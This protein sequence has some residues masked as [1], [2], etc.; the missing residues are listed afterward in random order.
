[1]PIIIIIII[2]FLCKYQNTVVNRNYNSINIDLYYFP[3]FL[4]F[5]LTTRARI[6]LKSTLHCPAEITDVSSLLWNL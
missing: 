4:N 1:M 5:C 2:L 3:G 6:L